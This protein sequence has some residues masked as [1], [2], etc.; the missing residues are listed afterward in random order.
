MFVLFFAAAGP[1]RRQPTLTLLGVYLFIAT[2]FWFGIV[3]GTFI[4]PEQQTTSFIVMLFAAPL[5]FTDQPLRISFAV[6]LGMIVYCICAKMT[7]T[8]EMFENNLINVLAYGIVGMIVSS[9]M[10]RIKFQ[11]Y[12]FEQENRFLSEFD[13][14][15]GLLNRRSY[16]QHIRKLSEDR[17]QWNMICAFD[18][19]GLKTVNDSLGHQAGDELII[20]AANCISAVF[21]QYGSCYR[22]GGDEFM[23]ILTG[24]CPEP[25]ELSEMLAARTRGWHGVLVSGMSISM[26]AV[27]YR[28]DVPLSQILHEADQKMYAAKANYYRM[29][30]IERRRTPTV[31]S[32]E[33]AADCPAKK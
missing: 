33:A 5:I 22:V 32:A 23:A 13:Q 7:Q 1:A 9:F 24:P 20:G 2:V 8:P 14:L 21:G 15:T 6:A 12:A 10:M 27:P 19:N 29:N 16:D 3:L 18:V 11:R 4:A 28:E 25:E 26:G 17:G 30:H 31:S